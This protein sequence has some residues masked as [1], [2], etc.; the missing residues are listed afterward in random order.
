MAAPR[1]A[2]GSVDTKAGTRI[3]LAA[4]WLCHFALWTF[5]DMFALLQEMTEPVTSTLIMFIAPTTA[6]VQALMAVGSLVGRQAVV[7]WANMIVVLAY[8]L[9]NIGFF[10][11]ATEGWEYYLGA[12]YLLFSLLIFWTAF[13][14][15][16]EE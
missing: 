1:V 9:F 3:L 6:I 13:R 2:P 7:R 10:V 4:L 11:D 16:D 14:W 8:V 5:G 15:T 12:F